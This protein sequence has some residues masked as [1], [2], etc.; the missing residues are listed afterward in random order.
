MLCVVVNYYVDN[1]EC[2]GEFHRCHSNAICINTDGTYDCQ[3]KSGYEGD[4]STDCHCKHNN[5]NF[6]YKL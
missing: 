4:G 2:D 5:S 3:C 1:N 6:V